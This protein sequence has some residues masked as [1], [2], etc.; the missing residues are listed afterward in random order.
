[1]FG[2][3]LNVDGAVGRDIRG[4]VF[5]A[6]V[7]GSVGRDV[8]LTVQRLTVD[9]SASVA[10][11]VLYRSTSDA[12]I[13]PDTVDGQIVQL[14]AQSN[15]IFGVILAIANILGILAFIVSGIIL[16]WLFRTT[17]AAS[18]G[19]IEQHPLKTF[20][21]GV[22]ALI[23]AP[24]LVLLLA[25][26]LVGLP[27][28]ALLLAMLLLSL[29]FGPV[30]AVTAGGDL[31]LRRKGGLFGGFVLGAVLWRLGIWLI[32]FVGAFLYLVA[33]I[34]G[35][36]GWV[37]GAW[38]VRA[39]RPADR[40]ALP[41]ALIVKDDPIPEGWEYPLAPMRSEDTSPLGGG[42]AGGGGGDQ[43]SSDGVPRSDLGEGDGG[44]GQAS[45]DG[46][47]RSDL[48]E[49]DGGGGQASRAP[50]SSPESG[51]ELDRHKP[52]T[53]EWGLPTR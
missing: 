18:V 24:M 21:I 31:L 15:F 22:L 49:G 1:M 7:A 40:E 32:P 28:A 45:S 36:G 33:L 38:R 12:S 35:V 11:D 25:V 52:G 39:A 5:T 16:L 6:T 37:L 50:D 13:A 29:V 26:T 20:I 51:D 14:P 2:G 43:A 53:D 42:A 46:V 44:G 27:L 10:G 17:G 34:W 3:T 48:G 47:P 9:S 8:D 41:P 19:A 4:R 23:G 30:P